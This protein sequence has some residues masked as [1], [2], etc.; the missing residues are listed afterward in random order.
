MVVGS[1]EDQ[2]LFW[3]ASSEKLAAFLVEK[4]LERWWLSAKRARIP[5]ENP[6]KCAGNADL[7]SRE[8]GMGDHFYC[9]SQDRSVPKAR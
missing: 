4:M 6:G 2:K 3:G 1:Y 5:K 8:G 7:G 9:K